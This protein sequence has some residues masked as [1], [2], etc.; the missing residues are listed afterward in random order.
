[1]VDLDALAG[2]SRSSR[3]SCCGG[4]LTRRERRRR[5]GARSSGRCSW[6]DARRARVHRARPRLD[7]R[8]RAH[9]RRGAHCRRR[10]TTPRPLAT[11]GL[12]SARSWPSPSPTA[13][14][15]TFLHPTSGAPNAGYQI[16]NAHRARASGDRRRPGAGRAK[17][18]FPPNAHTD[19]VFAIG[20]E[21]ASSAARARPSAAAAVSDRTARADRFGML[22]RQARCGPAQRST[23]AV[24]GPLPC[25]GSRCLRVLWRVVARDHQRLGDCQCRPR[26]SLCDHLGA[27]AVGRWRGY[28][29][30]RVPGP[31]GGR[32]AGGGHPAAPLRFVGR[33]VLVTRSRR[34]LRSLLPVGVGAAC[35]RR[36][37]RTC[38]PRSTRSWP[39]GERSP[40]CAGGASRS[41]GVGYA[42]ASAVLAAWCG[43]AGRRPRAERGTGGRT[44]LPSPSGRASLQQPP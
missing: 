26:A 41:F 42:V 36:S 38:A 44:G 11:V 16:L 27:P 31:G 23:S 8:A 7:G 19:F 43:G 35:G 13:V 34:R 12:T 10:A 24:T 18:H 32:R 33:R 14:R 39:W 3:C 28:G 40:S 5:P 37:R 20:E 21:S 22:L 17:Y 2:P 6:C 15:G 9:R 1:V 25:R 29:W 30:S 4:L